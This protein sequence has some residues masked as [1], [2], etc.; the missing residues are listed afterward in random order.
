LRRKRV[1]K[2]NG[3]ETSVGKKVPS[4][5]SGLLFPPEPKRKY[6]TVPEEGKGA[7]CNSCVE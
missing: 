6:S 2:L 7:I 5:H 4:L 3:N 1:Q